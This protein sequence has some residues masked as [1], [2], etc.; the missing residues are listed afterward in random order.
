MPG[1]CWLRCTGKPRPAWA[2][3]CWRG[4]TFRRIPSADAAINRPAARV[5]WSG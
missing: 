2:T 4:P 5:G 3:R 1:A